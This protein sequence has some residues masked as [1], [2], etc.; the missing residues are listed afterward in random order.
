M[1]LA[2][3]T[4]SGLQGNP[5]TRSFC[6]VAARSVMRLPTGRVGTA[7]TMTGR[8][9]RMALENFIVTL[10]TIL[11]TGYNK[12]QI[13]WNLSSVTTKVLLRGSCCTLYISPAPRSDPPKYLSP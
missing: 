8:D 7:E 1:P 13:I 11:R 6:F 5:L 9:N 2:K 12:K 4:V 10:E 3:I